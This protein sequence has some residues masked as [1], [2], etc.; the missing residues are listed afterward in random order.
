MIFCYVNNMSTI[1]SP[2]RELPLTY[3]WPPGQANTICLHFSR[4]ARLLGSNPDSQN[5]RLLNIRIDASEKRNVFGRIELP[6]WCYCDSL[7][8]A[9]L[10]MRRFLHPALFDRAGD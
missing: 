9:E 3:S 1:S 7:L 5:E 8:R 10:R 2:I 6:F 4:F